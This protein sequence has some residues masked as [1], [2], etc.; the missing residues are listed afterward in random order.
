MAEGSQNN[1]QFD[2]SLEPQEVTWTPSALVSHN[3]FFTKTTNQTYSQTGFTLILQRSQTTYFMNTYLPTFLL[4]IMSFIGFLI[5]VEMV[6]GRM[7]LIVTL[8]LMFVNIRSTEQSRG[9]RVSKTTTFPVKCSKPDPE[10][11]LF[12]PDKRLDSNGLLAAPVPDVC[13]PGDI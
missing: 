5:P 10:R 3:S 13:G 12:S 9:P 2:L 6:P 8:F 7:A 11:V 4:T 1:V